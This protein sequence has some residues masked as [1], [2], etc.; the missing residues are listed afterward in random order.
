MTS[1]IK[2][3]LI[4]LPGQTLNKGFI[5]DVCFREYCKN[6]SDFDLIA[7]TYYKSKNKS[8]NIK[9]LMKD[10]TIEYRINKKWNNEN[11]QSVFKNDSVLYFNHLDTI[12]TKFYTT[13]TGDTFKK[14]LA[15]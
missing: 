11:Y 14:M 7:S 12:D 2:N 15:K 8:D 13:I 5:V 10:I 1:L 4:I 6:I 9:D 3:G